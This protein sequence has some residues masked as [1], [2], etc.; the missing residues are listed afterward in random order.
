MINKKNW[1]FI[2]M[3]AILICQ[4][5]CQ[6]FWITNF[7]SDYHYEETKVLNRVYNL[8]TIHQ[9][10]KNINSNKVITLDKYRPNFED[11]I[12][13]IYRSQPALP[14]IYYY[15]YKI[16][17]NKNSFRIVPIIFSIIA[18]FLVYK[19]TL[20]LFSKQSAVLAIFLSFTSPYM[21]FSARSIREPIFTITFF[22][23]SLHFYFKSVNFIKLKPTIFFVFF[24]ILSILTKYTQVLF[25][26]SIFFIELCLIIFDKKNKIKLKY[27]KKRI[28]NFFLSFFLIFIA[29]FPMYYLSEATHYVFVKNQTFIFNQFSINNYILCS[30]FSYPILFLK[31]SLGVLLFSLFFISFMYFSILIL[32]RK[33]NRNVF[34]LFLIF[35]LNYIVLSFIPIKDNYVISNLIIL[36][37]IFISGFIVKL[38]NKMKLIMLFCIIINGVIYLTPFETGNITNFSTNL[39]CFG[40]NIYPFSSKFKVYNRDFSSEIPK[41]IGYKSYESEI[42]ILTHNL[43]N[44]SNKHYLKIIDLSTLNSNGIPFYMYTLNPNITV[45]YLFCRDI[46]KQY[47]S[48]NLHST[49]NVFLISEQNFSQNHPFYGGYEFNESNFY[50]CNKLRQNIINNL[51]YV[52]MSKTQINSQILVSNRLQIFPKKLN[53]SIYKIS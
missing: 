14:L 46:I 15:I 44:F 10:L 1:I 19:L 49:E 9:P 26:F 29:T 35:I 43:V 17:P 21:I 7:A 18:S 3:F 36:I 5:I 11:F 53:V 39:S 41:I 50:E 48:L 2:A 37:L 8:L 6:F 30:I 27:F 13:V 52:E 32:N 20:Q 51:T 31:E 45:D 47:N 12:N 40:N 28:T 38:K 33:I 24:S 16:F 4:I 22:L 34:T 25:I 42:G 23:F